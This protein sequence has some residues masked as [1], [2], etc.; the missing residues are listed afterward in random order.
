MNVM[1]PSLSRE[2]LAPRVTRG[3]ALLAAGLALTLG[4]VYW[5]TFGELLHRWTA[6]AQYSHGYLV[7]AFAL[8]LLWGRRSLPAPSPARPSW[9]GLPILAAGL[10]MHLAGQYVYFDWLSAVSLLPTLAGLTVLT[11]GWPALR[12]AW[13]AIAFL[14]F[15]VPLPFRAE[16]AL[17]APLQRV[18][19]VAST[20]LLQTL[21]LKAYAE[22]NVIRLG[23]VRL[24]VV[25]ACSGLSMLLTF[26]ALSTAVALVVRRPPLDRLLVCA[27]AVPIALASNVIRIT[28]TAVLYETV[29]SRVA[30]LVFHDLAGWLMIPL[31]L[32]FLWAELRLLSWVLV[33]AKARRPR[34]I[35]AAGPR[36]RRPVPPVVRARS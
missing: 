33:P 16:V 36:D 11:G 14:I 19:T 9:W 13:P 4:W 28:V 22:G 31:A 5:P 27:S 30:E 26:F 35:G 8:Y 2:R 17:A 6:D 34:K 24:G 21:G 15:M 23:E 29:G 20:Y 32:G 10:G 7:P 25:E 3:A 1:A 18:A 12:R